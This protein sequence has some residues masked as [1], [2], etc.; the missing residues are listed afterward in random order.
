LALGSSA[1]S[2]LEMA[3]AYT[4]FARGGVSINPKVLRRV[5]NNRGQ[6]LLVDS[7]EK[8]KAFPPEPV[9]ALVD[10]LQDVVRYGT[11]TQAK[12]ADRP[13]AGKTGTADAG[14]DIWFIGFT[15]DLVTAIWGGNDED[16][17]IP[18]HN[19]TGGVVM[20]KIW[21]SYNEA[22]YKT[23]P[24]PPGAFP[25]CDYKSALQ[26]KMSEKNEQMAKEETD[27]KDKL[28]SAKNKVDNPGNP[29]SI[30]EQPKV[31]EI[32]TPK[33]SP[34]AE[35]LNDNVAPAIEQAS[36]PPTAPD[37]KP[38]PRIAPSLEPISPSAISQPSV[39]STASAPTSQ[40]LVPAKT[41]NPPQIELITPATAGKRLYPYQQ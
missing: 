35:N 25:V 29:E 16:L 6:M 30:L 39:V 4:T 21:H 37:I 13:V 19:V 2:P 38:G 33:E 14:K 34:P 7:E 5:E 28:A 36:M 8:T 10:V 11:G 12:L 9:A 20:A 23:Y 24:T 1:I 31:E 18:G 32:E 15:P 41:T 22:Y 3:G 27:N 26:K 40:R 17:P